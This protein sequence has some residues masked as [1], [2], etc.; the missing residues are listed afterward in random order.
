MP[1]GYFNAPFVPLKGIFVDYR[2]Q[3][4]DIRSIMSEQ[5]NET[6]RCLVR[7]RPETRM[8]ID[9]IRREKG[10]T[11]TEAM[12]RAVAALQRQDAAAQVVV[13]AAKHGGQRT[14]KTRVA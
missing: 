6:P 3:V 12:A 13:G 5:T 1:Y 4:G 8:T 2:T 7:V 14:R 11:I 9:V 10:W